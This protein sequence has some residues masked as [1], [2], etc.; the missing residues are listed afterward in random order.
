LKHFAERQS[1]A[2]RSKPNNH[3][4]RKPIVLLIGKEAW[5][6][7]SNRR[8]FVSYSSMW[9]AG[10]LLTVNRLRGSALV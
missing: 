10:L 3:D 6:A 4:G 2:H 8:I 7:F 1:R 5:S 9:R